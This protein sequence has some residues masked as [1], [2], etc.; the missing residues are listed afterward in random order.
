MHLCASQIPLAS[1]VFVY[2]SWRQGVHM[3]GA[4]TN[5]FGEKLE[6]ISKDKLIKKGPVQGL[7]ELLVRAHLVTF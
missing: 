3:A 1:A 4:R 5:F 7:I 2:M 6:A